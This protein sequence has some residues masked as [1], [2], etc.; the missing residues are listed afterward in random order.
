MELTE[1][2]ILL[3]F[4][5]ISVAFILL[6]SIIYHFLLNSV[7]TIISI[8]DDSMIRKF[9]KFLLKN[10]RNTNI[11]MDGSSG[12][13]MGGWHFRWIG[14][15]PLVAKRSTANILGEKTDTYEIYALARGIQTVKAEITANSAEVATDDDAKFKIHVGYYYQVSPWSSTYETI[16]EL[17]PSIEPRP[18][19]KNVISM[20]CKEYLSR[21]NGS[22]EKQPKKA[23]SVLL[24][25]EPGIGKTDTC[26]YLASALK[27]S[28]EFDPTA[29]FGYDLTQPATTLNNVWRSDPSRE[30]PVILVFNEIDRAFVHADTESGHK[31]H[32]ALAQNKSSLNEVLDKLNRTPFIITVGTSNESYETLREKYPAYIRKGRFDIKITMSDNGITVHA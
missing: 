21:V 24:L 13:P 5:P 32:K 15:S 31:Y 25:G 20:V 27:T 16:D 29:I 11:V 3:A 18:Q 17:L 6:L 14:W 23:L 7:F 19:Q 8:N 22:F 26:R 1:F 30:K 2:I 4:Q 10:A 9:D 12:K 28:F